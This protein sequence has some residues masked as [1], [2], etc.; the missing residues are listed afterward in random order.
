MILSGCAANRPEPL[1]LAAGRQGAVDA[2]VTVAEQPAECRTSWPLLPRSDLV[3]RE[4]LSGIDRYEAYIT[5]Q[6]NPAKRR[7]WQFNEDIRAGLSRLG[8]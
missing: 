8:K 2:G 3:G 6:I 4:A 5:E 7:C 1:Q